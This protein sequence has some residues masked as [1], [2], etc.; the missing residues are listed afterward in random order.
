MT[1]GVEDQEPHRRCA[2]AVAPTGTTAASAKFLGFWKD[3]EPYLP[4]D[5]PDHPGFINWWKWAEYG[6]NGAFPYVDTQKANRQT[7]QADLSHYTE[8][9]LGQHDMK[10]GVQYTKGRGNR[11][12]GYFQNYV[13]FLYP[14]RW[15]PERRRRCRTRTVTPGSSSTT[16]S[17]RSI[18]S[19]PCGRPTPPACSSTTGGR[20]P[21]A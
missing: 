9:F 14:Y 15:T 2:V 6:I 10:F 5:R 13:N 19:S 18:R 20:R 21:S 12:E 4:D 1:Y 11:Q 3:D 7:I 16:T 17:T 8:R